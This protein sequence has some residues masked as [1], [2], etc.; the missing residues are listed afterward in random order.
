MFKKTNF[1]AR[2]LKNLEVLWIQS[3]EESLAR[4]PARNCQ[5]RNSNT[6]LRAIA[7]FMCHKLRRK[8][9]S[10]IETWHACLSQTAARNW[11]IFALRRASE[12]VTWNGRIADPC[13]IIIRHWWRSHWRWFNPTL[14]E[15]QRYKL[16]VSRAPIPRGRDVLIKII[17][18]WNIDSIV[19]WFCHF[20]AHF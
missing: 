18:L 7:L 1:K 4:L 14:A 8:T 10:S 3:C 15:D 16:H 2:L 19:W 12:F 17:S 13:V 11:Q 9:V 20:W 6:Q 5:P